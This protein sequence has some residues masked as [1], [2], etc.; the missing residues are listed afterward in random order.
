VYIYAVKSEGGLEVSLQSLLTLALDRCEREFPHHILLSSGKE[1]SVST[2]Q[3]AGWKVE[4]VW[5]L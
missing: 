5:I 4:L 1:S 3:E 2:E